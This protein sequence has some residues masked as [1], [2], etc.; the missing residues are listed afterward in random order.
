MESASF[1]G[2]GFPEALLVGMMLFFAA[3][4]LQLWRDHRETERRDRNDQS[5]QGGKP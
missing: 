4:W 2:F 1:Q 5:N 3:C